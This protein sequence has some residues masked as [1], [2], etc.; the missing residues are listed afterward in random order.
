MDNRETTGDTFSVTIVDIA[1]PNNYGVARHEDLVIFVPDATLGDTVEVAI[2]KQDKRFAYG[3]LVALTEPSP[4]RVKPQC[5]HFGRC[6]GCTLQHL[7]YEKQL[8][9]KKNHLSQTLKRIGNVDVDP[10]DMDPVVPSPH[11]YGYRN[12]LELAFG[13]EYGNTI[14]GLRERVS[15]FKK[16]SGQVIS[17]KACPVFGA[18]LDRIVP[19]FEGFAGTYNLAPYNPARRKGFL[20]HLIL[21]ES[22]AT[23]EIMAILETASGKLPD[24]N[25]LWQA[26]R[27]N[28]PSLRS[29][30]RVINNGSTDMIR[31]DRVEHLF[32]ESLITERLGSFS[33]RIYPQ[34]FF[35][36]NS[37]AAE[38][39]YQ[40]VGEIAGV[41]TDDSVLG[42]YCGMGPL[43]M[44]L[45]RSAKKVTGIDSVDMNIRG[46]IE[47]TGLN[48]VKNCSFHAG[49]MEDL[50]RTLPLQ[51]N[52]LLVVDPPR[53]GISP[54]GLKLITKLKVPKILYV[55][56]NPATLARDVKTFYEHSYKIGRIVPLDFF[57]HTSHLET[58]V[59]LKKG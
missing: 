57:P 10:A 56:C 9:I 39:L 3:E 18:T 55:S 8:E 37:S 16:Y 35:Q 11:I 44:F 13:E 58:A 42:L 25:V 46:A 14:L 48:A 38:A 26:L 41:R 32:G 1:L 2:R 53:T 19:F 17:I 20:R 22:K 51:M 40:R 4:F 45:S 5:L 49:R 43:E 29:F 36:P 30:Y 33:F 31:Y 50:L 24:I 15:P 6:G 12:K 34:S 54:E 28:V 52:D 47:N 59:I 21:R 23:G 7:T 27:A